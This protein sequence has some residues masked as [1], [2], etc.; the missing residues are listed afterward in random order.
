M[1]CFFLVFSAP[2]IESSY[3]LLPPFS[4][5]VPREIGEWTLRGQG[6]AQ[7]RIIH[8][9]SGI[10]NISGGVCCRIPTDAVE[11][12]S[13]IDISQKFDTFVLTLSRN[14]CPDI[15][16]YFNGLNISFTPSLD[17]KELKIVAKGSEVFPVQERLIKFNFSQKYTINIQ[18]T[19]SKIEISIKGHENSKIS[20]DITRMYD[21]VYFSLFAFSPSVCKEECITN[22]HGLTYF[23]KSEKISIDPNISKKNRKALKSTADARQL[24]KMERRA[25]MLTVSQYIE[26]AMSSNDVLNGDSA[27]AAAAMKEIKEMIGRAESRISASDLNYI[28]DTKVKPELEKAYARFEKIALALFQTRSETT[29]L[30]RNAEN[31]LKTMRSEINVECK[32]IEEEAKKIMLRIQNGKEFNLDPKT[33]EAKV[34]ILFIICG[35]EFVAYLCFFVKQHMRLS[36]KKRY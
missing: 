25:K 6:V 20:L 4:K 10:A 14:T 28:L 23:P 9:T 17:N 1:I 34:S 16:S 32:V 22:I 35:V 27:D 21:S 29:S 36:M 24:M 11:F 33:P 12:E 15:S 7:K 2:I 3:Q 18:K 31:S 26:E 19:Q 5:T 13:N 8:L 30:W